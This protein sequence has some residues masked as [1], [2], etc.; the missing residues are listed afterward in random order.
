MGTHAHAEI[1][2]AWFCGRSSATVHEFVASG[3]MNSRTA[4]DAIQYALRNGALVRAERT[5]KS[6]K[7]RTKYRATGIALPPPR[8]PT[9]QVSFDGLL[10]AWGI[11][12]QPIRLPVAT[13]RMHQISDN[14]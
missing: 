13:S 12:L 4:S 9:Q 2:L 8:R 11:A 14:E 6:A 5:G 1:L 3:L 7:E 10:E